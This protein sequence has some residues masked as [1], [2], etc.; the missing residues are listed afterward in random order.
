[1][2]GSGDNPL[3]LTQLLYG[4]RQKLSQFYFKGSETQN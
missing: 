2:Q 3:R 4:G 1:M